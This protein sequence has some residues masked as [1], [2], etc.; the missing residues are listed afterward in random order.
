MKLKLQF[1]NKRQEKVYTMVDSW[2]TQESVGDDE[3]EVAI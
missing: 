1:R 2:V 3:V